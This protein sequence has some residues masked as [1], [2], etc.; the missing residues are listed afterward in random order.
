MP[1]LSSDDLRPLYDTVLAPRLANLEH[2]RLVLR[3]AI[4]ASSLLA[5]LPLAM[6]FCGGNELAH[7]VAPEPVRPWIGTATIVA[8]IVG[9]SIAISRYALPGFTAYLNYR[10]KFKREI[11]GEIF[12]AV[13]PGAT[14]A[15]DSYIKPQ[16]FDQSGIFSEMGDV[17]GDDLVRGR[18]GDTP[19]EACE[20]DRHYS[21]GGKNSR[22]VSVFHGLFF[23]LDFNKTVRGRTVVQPQNPQNISLGS[24]RGLTAVTL[25]NPEFESRFNVF[26]TDPVE[27]RYILTPVLMERI[28]QIQEHTGR[29]LCLSFVNNRA[30]VAVDYGRALFEPSIK[31]TTSF[32]ALAEM[33]EHFGLAEL[34]V[35]ELD[36]NTR[37]WTKEVDASLLEE[38]PAVSP[39]ASMST[40][41][42][43]PETL[44]KQAAGDMY[45]AEDA[46]PAPIKPE[47]TRAIVERSSDVAIVRY[48]LAWWAF[49]T[50]AMSLPFIVVGLA[51]LGML[52]DPEWTLATLSATGQ[53]T[54]EGIDAFRSGALVALGIC[55]VVGGFISMY[56]VTYVRRVVIARDEILVTRGLGLFA[57]QYPRSRQTRILQMD[58]YVFLGKAD[59][60]KIVN[61]SLSPMLPS[62]EEARWVAW[63]MRR[64]LSEIVQY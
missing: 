22:T 30:F 9:I 38:A 49:M 1:T 48:R 51:A 12:R 62:K 42:L 50:M 29:P 35:R 16:I 45:V 19:F 2:D 24:R 46:G 10:A 15:P 28:L 8:I 33:L 53:L 64:A 52:I 18:I 37:I 36:L 4:V 47:R 40:G 13:S 5:G 54:E 60:V 25:E 41:T 61:P 3:H 11:V 32:A 39:I 17:R 7:L 23:R 55:F 31:D 26:S 56:W 27:A 6:Q 43:T 21:T 59:A 58:N 57:R 44:F 20:M 14:Y 63:E 34:V